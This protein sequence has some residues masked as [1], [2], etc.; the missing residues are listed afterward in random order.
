MKK[1]ILVFFL[2]FAAVLAPPLARA[3]AAQASAQDDCAKEYRVVRGDSMSVIA[4]RCGVTLSSLIMANPQI[5]NPSRI[6]VGQVIH[7]P[8]I[9]QP[10]DPDNP[11][12]VVRPEEDQ[13]TSEDLDNLKIEEGS[14]ER[15]I[16][17]DLSSQTVSAYE[18][19]EVIQTFLASSGTWKHPTVTGQFKIYLKLETDDMRGDDYF[20]EDV[21][22][23]MYFHKGYGLHGT[24]WHSNFGQPMSHGCV[25]LRTEDAEWL[26]AFAAEGTLVNVHY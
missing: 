23:T 24:Y 21:P 5:K 18:G 1:T 8:R 2:A 6:F 11:T 22:F 3:Q 7:M 17:V 19:R 15:W 25:N 9:A 12:I 14:Q 26:Y 13:L 10:V 4:K 16:D 20:V